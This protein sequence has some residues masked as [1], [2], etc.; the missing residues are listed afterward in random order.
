ME[1]EVYA[2]GLREN[3]CVG[4]REKERQQKTVSE[5]LWMESKQIDGVV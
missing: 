1:R 4:E 3:E 5:E 2:R